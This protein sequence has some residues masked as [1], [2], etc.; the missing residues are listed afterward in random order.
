MTT[1]D[2]RD[3]GVKK[4]C[5]CGAD[6]TRAKRLKSRDGRYWCAACGAADQ[7]KKGQASAQTC[8]RC[9]KA[10]SLTDFRRD[11]KQYVCEDCYAASHAGTKVKNEANDAQRKRLMMMIGLLAALLGVMGWM[12]WDYFGG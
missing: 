2:D 11:G 4:C 10:V 12:W 5:S 7:A 3:T 8:P 1:T 9:H 6:V